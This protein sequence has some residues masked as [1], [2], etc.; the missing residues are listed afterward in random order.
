M[1]DRTVPQARSSGGRVPRKITAVR[2]LAAIAIG[3]LLYVAHEAFVPLALAALI[4]LVLSG[5]VELL[6]SVGVPRGVSAALV[7]L[8]ILGM[9]VGLTDLLWEPAQHWFAEAPH[10]VRVIGRKIRPVAQF[11]SRVDELRNSAGNIGSAAHAS[12]PPPMPSA[13]QESSPALLFNITLGVGISSLTVLILTL[14]LLAG[15]P[16]MLARMTS[17]L[18]SDLNSAHVIDLIDKVRR[19]VGRFYVTTTLINVGLG[20]A[21]GCAMMLCAMPNPFLWG[22]VAGVLNFIPYA[23]PTATLVLLSSVAFVSFDG[24]AH[25]AAVAGSF[26]ALTAVEGQVVQPLLVGRRLQLNPMLVFLALWFGGMFWGIA[27]IVLATPALAALKVLTQHSAP[28]RPLAVF[29]SPQVGNAEI[30]GGELASAEP[31]GPELAGP[32][33]VTTSPPSV[34]P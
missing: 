10:T 7:L 3:V 4:A 31:P 9:V 8:V 11:M 33:A 24:F 16:P 25:V 20:L 28:G 18:V 26:L 15:G 32:Q 5:P 23:G 6:R 17:A 14:F 13:P 21:T 1:E 22:T 2:V 27:G 12:P 29:L 34:I 19:E 30:D